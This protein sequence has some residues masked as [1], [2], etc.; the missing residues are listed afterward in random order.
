MVMVDDVRDV[1]RKTFALDRYRDYYNE[2]ERMVEEL[3]INE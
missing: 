2:P 1:N 3:Y